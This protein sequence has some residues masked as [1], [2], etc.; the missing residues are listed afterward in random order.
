MLELRIK[1]GRRHVPV[2]DLPAYLGSDDARREIGDAVDTL[3]AFLDD[4]GGDPDLE[5]IDAED[6]FALSWRALGPDGPG[7]S[8]GDPGGVVESE[9][10][11]DMHGAMGGDGPGCALSDPDCAADDVPCDDIDQDREPDEPVLPSYGLDQTKGPQELRLANDV[12]AWRPHRDRSRSRSCE[13]VSG[14][15]LVGWAPRYALRDTAIAM[16]VASDLI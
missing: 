4:L 7:C 10:E 15:S 1:Q 2:F 5:E 16:G 6:S 3:I 12:R 8:I 9:D 14:S 11:P 13:R